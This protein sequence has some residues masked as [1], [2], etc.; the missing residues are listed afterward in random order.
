MS[1]PRFHAG[2]HIMALTMDSDAPFPFLSPV[3][4]GSHHGV[5]EIRTYRLRPG[6]LAPTLAAWE[7]AIAPARA[8][9]AHLVTNLY[10]LDGAPRITHI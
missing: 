8:Y 3:R 9:T 7:A 1:A 10:A 6:G 4:I 5:Y 2:D